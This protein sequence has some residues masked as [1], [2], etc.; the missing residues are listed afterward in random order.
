MQT[1]GPA[2][3]TGGGQS[4]RSPGV[5]HCGTLWKGGGAFGPALLVGLLALAV[6]MIYLTETSSVPFL[7]HFV[8]DA[9][10]YWAWAER[11]SGGDWLGGRS[12]YQAPLYPYVLAVIRA[13]GGESVTAV[14]TVQAVWGALAVGC[15]CLGTVRWFGRGAG[16]TAGVML[17][18]YP[19]A[20]FF[21]GVIQKTSLGCLLTCV[22][23]L[24]L[25]HKP[26]AKAGA[27]FIG[28]LI[29]LLMLTRENAA[30][31]VPVLLVWLGLAGRR[32]GARGRSEAVVMGAVG[33]ALVLMPVGLRN[34]SVS[35]EWS[36]STF[37][38]GPNLYIGNRQGASGR[39]DPLVRGH[40]TPRFERHDATI[41]AVEALGR[42]LTPAEVSNYWTARALAEMRDDPWAWLRLMGRKLAMVWNRYE[43]PDVESQGIYADE[44]ILLRAL[45]KV[46]HFGVLCPLAAMGLMATWNNRRRLWVLYVM[47]ATMALAVAFFYVMARYRF[48]LVP[49]LMPF[50][51]AGLIEVYQS[52]RRRTWRTLTPRLVVAAVVAILVNVPVH[53]ERRLNALATMNVGVALAEQGDVAGAI[54]YF[55][56]AVSS[57]PDSAEARNNLAQALAVQGRFAGAIPHYRAALEL[58]PTLLGVDYNLAVALEQIGR[59]DEALAHYS[60][61]LDLDPTDIAAADAVRRLRG[62]S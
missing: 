20:L 10:G 40:E 8:G 15:L 35:G 26:V 23:L 59:T 38:M 24:L 54:R 44:S 5:P 42:T 50:A 11:L 34:W 32:G 19:P 17:A 43:V 45:A 36:V 51:A 47:I 49:L 58:A 13:A 28:L 4:H 16:V 3:R 7:R 25:S 55:S 62:Q 1:D 53:P 27:A 48:P 21:D 52:V 12:F 39:Y 22:L 61:A 2:G 9:A 14:R 18:L 46:W 29:G 60:R 56:S 30:V 41:L 57:S 33:L 31:W 37:Q 6:R